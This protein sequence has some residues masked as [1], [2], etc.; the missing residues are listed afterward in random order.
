MDTSMHIH[1]DANLL[2]RCDPVPKRRELQAHRSLPDSLATVFTPKLEDVRCCK[3]LE[4]I[5]ICSIAR[6]RCLP[7]ELRAE[8]LPT[9]S[10]PAVEKVVVTEHARAEC[11]TCA[12][13]SVQSSRVP[14]RGQGHTQCDRCY[15]PDSIYNRN[16]RC[17]R[18][19]AVSADGTWGPTRCSERCIP[20][21]IL[22]HG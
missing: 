2:T 9:I 7:A 13:E 18:Q 5:V 1:P 12:L 14:C 10:T 15:F 6:R 19:G 11:V 3:V 17:I 21:E 22:D 16:R 4:S 8:S 20:V